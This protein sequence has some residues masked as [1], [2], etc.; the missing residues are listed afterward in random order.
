MVGEKCMSG[1]E[2]KGLSMSCHCDG[3]GSITS[4]RPQ[5]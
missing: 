4:M 2:Q 3:L 1:I 5:I